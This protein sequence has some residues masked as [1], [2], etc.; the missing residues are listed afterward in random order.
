MADLAF[1][2]GVVVGL[3]AGVILCAILFLPEEGP[4]A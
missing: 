4:D 2:T 3:V 1:A